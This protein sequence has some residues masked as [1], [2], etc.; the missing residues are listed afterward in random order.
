MKQPSTVNRGLT[1][2]RRLR[3]L[4]GL[5][6]SLGLLIPAAQAQTATFP[7]NVSFT[8]TNT[9]G[10]TLGGAG[11]STAYLTAGPSPSGG[12][13]IDAD[14][15]GVLRLTDAANFQAGYAIDNYTFPTPD[16][17]S[18]SFEFFS[19]GTTSDRVA[20][21]FT[22]FLVDGDGTI[23]GNGF[24]I[25]G[26]GGSLGYANRFGSEGGV[27]KGYLGIG[28]DAYGNYGIPSESKTGGY[29]G[30]TTGAEESNLL[31]N[32]VSLRGPYNPDD[33]QRLSGYAYLAGSNTLDFNLAV[34]TSQ[35]KPGSRITL[36][37]DPGY[38]YRKA[39]VNVIPVT[40]ADGKIKYRITVRI[41]HGQLVTTTV[42]NIEITNP[43]PTLRVG[44]GA[45][46]GG[47]NSI[48]EIRALAIVQAPIANDDYFQ[49]KYNQP[50]NIGVLNNDT[51]GG[52]AAIDRTTVDMDPSTIG[53]DSVYLVPQGKFSVNNN[54][55]VKFSPNGRFSGVV[56]IPYTVLNFNQD[57]SNPGTLTITVTG[58]DVQTVASGLTSIRPGQTTSYAVTTTNN[59]NELAQNVIPVLTLPAGFTLVGPLPAGATSDNSTGP[60][61]I[62]FA[63]ATLEATQAV[64]NNVQVIAGNQGTYSVATNYQYPSDGFI[65]DS[66]ARNNPFTLTVSVDPA[67]PLPVQLTTFTATAV[68][69]DAVLNWQT[70][71]EVNNHYFALERARDGNT[72]TRIGTVAGKGTTTQASAYRYVDTG[73]SARTTDVLYYRL[74]QVDYDGKE[75]FSAVQTVRFR[76]S[77]ASVTLYPNPSTG[78]VTLDLS[79][80]P[81]DTYVVQVFEA[82]GRLVHHATYQ[83]GSCLL[84]VAGLATGTYFV[85][86]QGTSYNKVLPFS[87]Q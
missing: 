79:S 31:P 29:P 2:L 25:G 30:R 42:N 65:P 87:R 81:A 68:G 59:G 77:E 5:A 84:P 75:S 26:F 33:P 27:T 15:M 40:A 12:A 9:N 19:Y 83:P 7:R 17:F 43:P 41:Q 54:G 6:L 4:G 70:A 63:P 32:A 51:P 16:G 10:F 67:A 72:F 34:G 61:V 24:G 8:G 46:T 86:V 48:Q 35:S 82:T 69:A 1:L 36:P 44:F 14:G 52:G 18:I 21:G 49:T 85:K 80:L 11:G 60:T 39:Y 53:T 37:T 22:V 28:I 71:Q 20:D 64:S 13:P 55:V 66:I 57:L 58:A 50:I 47:F 78:S 76:Y 3:K 23:P 62:T 56:S 74:R 73:A 38:G 45:A